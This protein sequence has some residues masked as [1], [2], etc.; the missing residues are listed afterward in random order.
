V[1]LLVVN[2]DDLGLCAA[3]NE[4]ILRAHE[5]GIVTSASLMVDG[6]TA[7]AAA[8]AAPPSLGLGLHLDLGEW[9]C[10]AGEWRVRRHVVDADDPGAVAR[11]L[12][13]QLERFRELTGREPD[14][15]DSHQ[16]AHRSE[17]VRSIMGRRARE[18]RLPLRHHGRFAYRGDFY[19]QGRAGAPNP[20]AI[21]AAALAAIVTT[22]AEGATEL[23]CHPAAAPPPGTEYAAERVAELAALCDPAVAA[24][25]ASAGV[26]KCTFAAA[27]AHL[28]SLAPPAHR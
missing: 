18:L 9:V 26:R 23:C 17:P 1:R 12:E 16:H 2:A 19:G 14:H 10:E 21:T 7:P 24:A 11:E 4:G 28:L 6:E 27:R 15:L 13:R 20:D 25:V 3:V 5:Q 22:L 8:V